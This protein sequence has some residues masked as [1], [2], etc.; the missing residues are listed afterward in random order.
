MEVNILLDWLS[1]RDGG[2]LNDLSPGDMQ[3]IFAH[4]RQEMSYE[5]FAK[6]IGSA[7]AGRLTIHHVAVS[8]AVCVSLSPNMW[9]TKAR[10]KLLLLRQKF[11]ELP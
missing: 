3:Q 8:R 9:L 6:D 7:W 4:I 1:H 2:S 10:R 5:S 11:L